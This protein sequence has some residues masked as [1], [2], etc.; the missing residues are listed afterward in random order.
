[1]ANPFFTEMY[2]T[3]LKAVLDALEPHSRQGLVDKLV[4]CALERV[5]STTGASRA[6]EDE[7]A[8]Y[9][10]LLG[11]F[12]LLCDLVHEE[13]A[14]GD[15]LL[16][17]LQRCLDA[18]DCEANVDLLCIACLVL[19]GV[20]HTELRRLFAAFYQ[21]AAGLREDLDVRHHAVLDNIDRLAEKEFAK[22]KGTKKLVV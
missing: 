16:E 12:K 18:L 6:S 10:K 20:Q 2:A 11:V 7:L 3:L 22:T 8:A 14:D 17:P 15:V 21:R 1:M 9:R 5:S 19:G 4:Q 13:I